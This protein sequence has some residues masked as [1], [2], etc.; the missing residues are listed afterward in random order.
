MAPHHPVPDFVAPSQK[1]LAGNY[2][3][4]NKG[5]FYGKSYIIILNVKKTLISIGGL[6]GAIVEHSW[7]FFGDF[8]A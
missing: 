5:F 1:L 3:E 4:F 7:S 2:Y 6:L 8:E